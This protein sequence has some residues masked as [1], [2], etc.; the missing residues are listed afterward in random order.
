MMMLIY[1][2]TGGVLGTLLRYA[3]AGSPWGTLTVNIIGSFILG[4]AMR[5][6]HALFVT[7]E[8][9]G[10]IAVGFCGALTT[11]STYSYEVIALAE[12][13]SVMRAALY[14]FGSL[15][16]GLVAVLAGVGVATLLR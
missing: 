10:F 15:G 2:A 13:G 16:A 4:F 9:R 8:M 6:S 14:M 5:A 7:P 3:L 1:V 11:F 12:S